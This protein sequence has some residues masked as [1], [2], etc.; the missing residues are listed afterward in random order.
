MTAEEK[1]VKT[2]L[3]RAAALMLGLAAAACSSPGEPGPGSFSL[4]VPG[5]GA[6]IIGDVT[7]VEGSG[8]TRSLLVEQVPTRSA[9]YPIARVYVTAS[10]RILAR[11]GGQVTRATAAD[12]TTG[13]RV[14][15]WF[16]GAVRESYPVQAD[17]GTVLIER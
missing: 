15:A 4:S 16:T 5:E 3:M 10:T 13:T 2:R 9:G 12:L 6:D 8:A 14:H 1:T 17:A 7:Q 11:S